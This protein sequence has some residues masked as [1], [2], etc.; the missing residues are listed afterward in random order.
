MKLVVRVFWLCISAAV[1]SQRSG[2][3]MLKSAGD[4]GLVAP[5][6]L[7]DSSQD[8]RAHRQ[9]HRT[10]TVADQEPETAAKCTEEREMLAK[11]LDELI[12]ERRKLDQECK[13]DARNYKDMIS[14]TDRQIKYLKKTVAERK[15]ESD[16][17]PLYNAYYTAIMCAKFHDGFLIKDQKTE[18][19]RQEVFDICEGRKALKDYELKDL[20]DGLGIQSYGE[21]D[22]AAEWQTAR[23]QHEEWPNLYN[24]SSNQTDINQSSSKTNILRRHQHGQGG[25]PFLQWD[26]AQQRMHQRGVKEQESPKCF[27]SQALQE[28]VDSTRKSRNDEQEHCKE[29]KLELAAD[30][31]KKRGEEDA[32]WTEYYGHVTQ[33]GPIRRE[34]AKKVATKFCIAVETH[35]PG[36]SC[37]PDRALKDFYVESCIKRPLP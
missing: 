30:L 20:D 35:S 36:A 27:Q 25:K 24:Q 2:R 34:Q 10:P 18:E 17:P 12:A 29:S 3:L 33:K 13:A 1:S 15:D 9:S 32:L 19:T 14:L 22:R 6:S 37:D 16:L 31:K 21:V 23:Q 8:R 7:K 4:S 28:Q 11:E 26:E 5:A